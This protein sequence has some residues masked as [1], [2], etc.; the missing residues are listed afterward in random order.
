MTP[1]TDL[2]LTR[3][4]NP[5]LA[6]P[7]VEAAMGIRSYES[8]DSRNDRVVLRRIA[9]E[10]THVD[11]L[12]RRTKGTFDV[13]FIKGIQSNYGAFHELIGKGVLMQAGRIDER[14]LKRALKEVN[15]GQGGAAISLALLGCV[16]IFC[17]SWNR[18]QSIKRASAG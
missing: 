2:F 8:F 1:V 16:E 18:F 4:V 14:E 9:Y 5:F 11:V 3:R 17:A 6:Q 10:T 7:I 15:V 12:W 13:G